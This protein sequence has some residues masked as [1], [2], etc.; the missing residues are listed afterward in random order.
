MKT[1]QDILTQQ[2][3]FE[4][5][6]LAEISNQGTHVQAEIDALAAQTDLT[7]IA[8]AITASQDRIIAAVQSIPTTPTPAPAEPPTT[9]EPTPEGQ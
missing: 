7:P 8:D 6:V 5:A 3:D 4:S 2:S 1:V 9:T